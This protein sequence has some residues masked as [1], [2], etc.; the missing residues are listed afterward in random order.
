[1][2]TENWFKGSSVVKILKY[3]R[4]REFINK[5]TLTDFIMNVLRFS[6][7]NPDNDNSSKFSVYRRVNLI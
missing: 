3:N 2:A 5:N 6:A 4:D 1:M 7:I